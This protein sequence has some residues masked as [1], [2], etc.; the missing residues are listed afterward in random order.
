MQVSQVESTHL[1]FCLSFHE[2]IWLSY[3]NKLQGLSIFEIYSFVEGLDKE[4]AE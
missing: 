2:S 4:H 1:H 3:Y